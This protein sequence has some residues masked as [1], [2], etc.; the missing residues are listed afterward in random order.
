[1]TVPAVLGP[2]ATFRLPALVGEEPGLA[3]LRRQVEIGRDACQENARGVG[4]LVE[5]DVEGLREG[6]VVA[7]LDG[8]GAVQG[9]EAERDRDRLVDRRRL[10]HLLPEGEPERYCDHTR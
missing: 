5:D 7:H 2:K 10:Q 8:D 3:R 1:M 9:P 4:L 6:G